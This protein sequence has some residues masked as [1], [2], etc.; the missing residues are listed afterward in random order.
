MNT[1]W[2]RR[3]QQLVDGKIDRAA[4]P[5]DG[6]ICGS[7]LMRIR[8]NIVRPLSEMRLDLPPVGQ[9]APQN[10]TWLFGRGAS[11]AS[12]LSWVV[13]QDWKDDLV[14]ERVTREAHVSLITETLREEMTR[15]P[16]D[17]PPYR[18][19]L[20][21][22]ASRTVDQGHHR[23][24]TTNWD[25]LLQR[26]IHNWINANRP[27]YA[28]RFLSTH[29]MVYHLN[30]SIEPGEFQNRS[31]FMLETDSAIA[32]KATYEANQALNYLLWSSL[33]IIVGMSFEC[34]MD[35]GL[36]A[37]LRAH[38]DN[39]PIG[40]ALFV[41]VEPNKETLESTYAKLAYCFPRAG[42]IR[43]NSGLAEWIDGGMPELVPRLFTGANRNT[44]PGDPNCVDKAV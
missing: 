39:V 4:L 30:G 5:G 28:P 42:G 27:G 37:T 1:W 10:C 36:L 40:S 38:E 9:T 18:R 6:E 12:G 3:Y 17:S 25:Y 32:R 8:L 13:P 16:Q 34:D 22:M 11:V 24:L 2:R 33:I 43:V 7:A 31:P 20:D 41:I 26:D 35:R 44:R 19:L 29:G 23:L 14:A 21:I 15:V